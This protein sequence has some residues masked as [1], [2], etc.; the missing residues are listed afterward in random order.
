MKPMLLTTLAGVCLA[1]LIAQAPAYA[2]PTAC[3][4]AIK[5][6]PVRVPR[7]A[8]ELQEAGVVFVRAE[9]D[10]TGRA[11]NVTTVQS[12]GKTRLDAAAER[13]VLKR[14]TFDVSQ[15][16]VEQLPAVKVVAVEFA[17]TS[18]L[19]ANNAECFT[20]SRASTYGRQR[21][22]ACLAAPVASSLANAK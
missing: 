8:L 19:S 13:A 11:H 17:S 22:E 18:R 20:S 4:P 21:T 3:E 15:C 16:A 2:E 14:W 5:T 12:S 7:R 9:I 6:A 1:G 10:A